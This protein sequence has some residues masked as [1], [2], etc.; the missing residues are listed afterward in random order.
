MQR[1]LVIDDEDQVRATL[2]KML[3][4]AGYEVVEAGN[5]NEGIRLYQENPTDLVITDIIMPD[6]EGM[7]TIWDLKRE[8]P[9]VKIIA[10]SGG[11]GFEPGPYLEIAE[12]FG[13][14]RILSKPFDAEELL[15]AIRELLE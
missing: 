13:A 7:E 11:G 2:R 9:N 8:Y 3:E 1:I 15:V 6:K 5:G 12:G 10:I 4:N 14:M